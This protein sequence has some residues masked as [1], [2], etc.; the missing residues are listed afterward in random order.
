MKK[1]SLS[2][3]IGDYEFE[4]SDATASSVS[5][6]KPA[7]MDI[8]Q[9]KVPYDIQAELKAILNRRPEDLKRPPMPGD[10]PRAYAEGAPE[11]RE[12]AMDASRASAENA[13]TPE[14]KA[15]R[16]YEGAL[17]HTQDA[18]PFFPH[19]RG[20]VAG[21]GA[22]LKGDEFTPAYEAETVHAAKQIEEAKR[23]AP[24]TAFAAA[25]VMMAMPGGVA[26]KTAGGRIAGATALGSAYGADSADKQALTTE[27]R[28]ATASEMLGPALIGAGGGLAGGLVGEA[29]RPIIRGA[30]GREDKAFFREV[31]RTEG[32]EGAQAM[33]AKNKEALVKDYE[34][35]I[36]QR[37]DPVLR[38]AVKL[39]EGKGLPVVQKKIQPYAEENAQLYSQIDEAARDI[40]KPKEVSGEVGL[41][42]TVGRWDAK[43]ENV[44]RVVDKSKITLPKGA[45]RG[46]V[47][48]W[49]A[50]GNPVEMIPE[51]PVNLPK[52]KSEP[53][54]VGLMNASRLEYLLEK[55]K[56]NVG[57]EAAAR[58]DAIKA[59]LK[60]HWVPRVWGGGTE[61]PA[62]RFRAWLTSVQ[63][64]A[65][66][67]PGSLNATASYQSVNEA[68]R[69]STR[70]FNE[71]LDS[72]G[73][74][75]K[76]V[77]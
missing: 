24:E 59:H 46:T 28:G 68:M 66:S 44:E 23:K 16:R 47:A 37:K 2:E 29:M 45:K 52:V 10:Q 30:P 18:V 9:A 42:G 32:G 36:A 21:A 65:A 58:I 69:E 35:V 22:L 1:R 56:A 31:T 77:V 49:D 19:I 12:I 67:V 41:R 11:A 5:P 76:S 51:K 48:K 63:N 71:Y 3:M 73:I 38:A 15:T 50:E 6:P 54:R 62:G 40:P 34:N 55:S 39:P 20:A 43:G 33:L 14:H 17:A 70:I 61:M 7:H 27:G 60:N 13:E 74:D 72:V 26:A 53:K 8:G 75:R 64:S 57:P 4:G 25:P